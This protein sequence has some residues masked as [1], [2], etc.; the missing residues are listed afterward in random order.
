[1]CF[2]HFCAFAKSANMIL[3][4]GGSL[5]IFKVLECVLGVVSELTSLKLITVK[6]FV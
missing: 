3:R 1:M 6:T 4:G 2:A 5:F